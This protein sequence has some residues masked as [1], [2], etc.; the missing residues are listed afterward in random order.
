MSHKDADNYAAKH[1]GTVPTD[2]RIS[3]A[4]QARGADGRIS[5]KH[6]HEIAD[7]FNIPPAEVGRTIDLLDTRI[8]ECQLGLFGHNKDKRNIVAP[9]QTVSA[10]LREKIAEK[11][12]GHRISCISLWDI[13]E[14]LAISKM[15][16]TAACETLHLKICCCQLGAFD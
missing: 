15:E 7:K 1:I 5:C 8:N 13:A 3:N 16:M 10:V 11:Q 2:P 6:A 4:I 14:D 12:E 9:A